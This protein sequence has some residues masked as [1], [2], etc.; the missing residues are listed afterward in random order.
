[1]KVSLNWLSDYVDV[2]MPAEELGDLMLRLG[3]PCEGI[4]R[5]DAD[6]VLDIEVTSNRPDLLGH[7]G[8]AREVAAAT[9]AAFRAPE[10]ASPPTAGK[11]DELTAVDVRAADL[12]PRYAARVIRGV[13]VAPSPAWLVERLE[14]IGMRP[15]NNVV[16][17]TNYVLME[18][19]QPLHCFDYDKLAGGRIVVRRADKGET[20]VSIDGTECKLDESM[21]VIADAERPVAVAGIM[22]GLN[23]EVGAETTNLLIESAQFDPLATRKT[24]R[25]LQL[26][27]ESNFRFERGVD[28]VAVDQ[29]SLRACRLIIDLAG[30]ELAEGV[31]DVWADP[32]TP[33]TVT[34]RTG[35]SDAV[36]GVSIAP[37]RQA[38]ILDGLGLDARL[39]GDVIVCT[40][41][42]FR[43]DL[44]READLIEEVARIE[45]YDKIP[46][47]DSITH[48]V[49]AEGPAERTEHHLR[50]AMSAAGFDETVSVAYIEPGEAKLFGLNESICVDQMH[51]KSHNA[52]RGTLLPSLLRVCRTNQSAG[53]VDLRLY[54]LAAVF[55]PSG[56]G[57]LPAER[58]ELAMVTTDDLRDLR[59]ALEAVVGKVRPGAEIAA[60]PC[61]ASGFADGAA[62]AVMLDDERIGT[63]GVVSAG[64]LDHFSLD[65]PLAAATVNFDALRTAAGE[66][67]T[68]RPVPK[69]PPVRRD[70]SLIVDESITWRQL[71]DAMSGVDQPLLAAT[72]YV[73]TFRGKPIPAGR[74]SVTVRLTYRSDTGTLRSEQVDEQIEQV[75]SRMKQELSA[76]LR[77]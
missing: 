23:T 32:P 40:P 24:S 25:A 37:R 70:L 34:L 71:A 42:S 58:T 76:E 47:H 10:I 13:K 56:D 9:G 27:S 20:L 41:P 33:K 45:G 49:V 12:C 67:R 62:A 54:E 15:V 48:P 11:A 3:F 52:L 44:T 57:D 59:G 55:P 14:A 17:V 18:Y 75:V 46:V 21:L 43:S 61:E 69:F 28:P 1:M 66:V 16:D 65:R 19:S 2:S 53:N 39:D 38:E 29:A 8:V 36:L 60:S 30:G 6:I 51:R 73:T 50:G 22:G 63:I 4:E 31:V 68:Y 64:A 74:K 26:M 72:D 5:T 77:T 7:L 35:R